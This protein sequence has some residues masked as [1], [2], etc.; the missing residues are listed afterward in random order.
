MVSKVHQLTTYEA[1]LEVSAT[2]WVQEVAHRDRPE[3]REV[4]IQ[5]EEPDPG[6]EAHNK[7]RQHLRSN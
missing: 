4:D 7:R 2:V 6:A 1:E 5:N 3:E